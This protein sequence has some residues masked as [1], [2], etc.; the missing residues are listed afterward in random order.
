MVDLFLRFVLMTFLRAGKSSHAIWSEKRQEKPWQLKQRLPLIFEA[1]RDK[2]NHDSRSNDYH[3]TLGQIKGLNSW[4]DQ[5]VMIFTR[6]LPPPGPPPSWRI[7]G[8]VSAL[9]LVAECHANAFIIDDTCHDR[10][11]SDMTT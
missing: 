2:K 9:K 10:I 4:P 11:V 8:R 1:R 7:S 6:F 3:W 5:L